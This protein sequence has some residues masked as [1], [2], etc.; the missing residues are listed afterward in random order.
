MHVMRLRSG[1]LGSNSFE[2]NRAQINLRSWPIYNCYERKGITMAFSPIF[3]S[4]ADQRSIFYI[5][6]KPK[7]ISKSCFRR[8]SRV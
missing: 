4:P 7:D 1:N 8:S 3:R 6:L 5:H 2:L